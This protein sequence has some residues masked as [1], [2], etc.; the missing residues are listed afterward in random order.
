MS[1]AE[2]MHILQM[3]EDGA[4]TAEDGLRLL[5][6][7][8]GN[9][10][11]LNAANPAEAGAAEANA[12]TAGPKSET[13]QEPPII[14][15]TPPSSP[16]PDFEKW[17]RWWIIP[18]WVGVGITAVGALIMY[19]AY[20]NTGLSFWLACWSLPFALGVVVIALAAA[21]RTAKWLHVRVKT[22][23][24]TGPRNIAI[25]FPLPIHLTAWFLRTFGDNIPNLKNTGVD[26][27]ILAMGDSATSDNPLYVEVNEGANG[28]HVQVYIG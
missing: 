24:E 13:S 4:I 9:A 2:R 10:P 1:D 5:N 25:S 23:R 8:A 28:E 27:L 14:H 16:P 20:A 22:G 26:E 3:I 19:W 18:L 17:K 15:T 21:S 11:Q 6:A 12:S 7:I